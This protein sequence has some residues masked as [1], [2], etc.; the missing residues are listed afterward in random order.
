MQPLAAMLSKH[1]QLK[2]RGLFMSFDII[3]RPCRY[4]GI[5]VE[6]TNP[7]TEEVQTVWP[8]SL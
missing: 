8:A 2:Y 6:K 5:V 4:K 1:I 7:F 3:F